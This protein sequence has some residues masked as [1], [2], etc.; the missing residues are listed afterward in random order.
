[1]RLPMDGFWLEPST[2]HSIATLALTSVRG[3]KFVLVIVKDAETGLSKS[4]GSLGDT[5][6]RGQKANIAA[7]P[8]ITVNAPSNQDHNEKLWPFSF[9]FLLSFLIY[10][11][12]LLILTS[13]V[14]TRNKF[15]SWTQTPQQTCPGKKNASKAIEALSALKSASGFGRWPRMSYRISFINSFINST[16]KRPT[17]CNS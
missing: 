10:L 7:T 5:E 13:P 9:T 6:T 15:S 2:S 8:P 16:A 14:R 11:L 12:A 17:F 3:M 4:T 1:M